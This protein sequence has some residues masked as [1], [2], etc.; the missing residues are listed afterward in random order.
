[1]AM[2]LLAFHYEFVADFLADDQNHNLVS[3]DIIQGTQV[4]CAQFKL[5]ERIGTQALDR[6]R[7]RRGLL[8]EAGL[9]SRFQDPLL[10]Y[11][12]R[13]EL[14]V[15]VLRDGNFERHAAVS[16]YQTAFQ[17]RLPPRR[18]TSPPA[19]SQSV[20]SAGDNRAPA[21]ACS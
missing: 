13:P 12:Q 10:A 4:S 18:I 3:L 1:M 11:W 20:R 19:A 14:P 7:G 8:Q 16:A 21:K 6:F 9:D 17:V 15:G 5:S 2:K